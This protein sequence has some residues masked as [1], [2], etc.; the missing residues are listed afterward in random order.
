MSEPGGL[1][2]VAF[3]PRAF[4]RIIDLAFHYSVTAATGFFF[5]IMLVVAAG[6]R[7]APQV[8]VRLRK[9]SVGGFLL[10][11]LGSVAYEVICEAM[12]GSTFGKLLLGMVVVQEDGAPCTP[13]AAI[14][15]SFA[16]FVDGLF[17]GLIAYSAMSQ[18]PQEQRLGD[19][20]AGTVVCKKEDVPHE[21]LRGLGRF[22][23][24]LFFAILI[25]SGFAMLA[26]LL[27]LNA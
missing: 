22:A 26:L 18:S 24:G 9:A 19:E 13:K 6:G 15:R 10:V 4:A 21:S 20:W 1:R 5:G 11:L 16:Y 27:K 2:G 25:D 8:L 3:W 14:I 23:L 7:V 12:H 17:F